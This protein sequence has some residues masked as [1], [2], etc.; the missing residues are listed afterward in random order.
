MKRYCSGM[1]VRLAFA[2]PLT[3]A[4][5]LVVDEVLAVGDAAFQKSAFETHAAL[6]SG[7]GTV[8][9]VSHNMGTVASLCKSALVLEDGR[10]IGRGEAREQV[11]LYMNALGE[12]IA[13]DVAARTDRGGNG[14]ARLTDIRLFDGHGKP[15]ESAMSG[16]PLTIRLGYRGRGPL[17][18]AEV[19]LRWPMSTD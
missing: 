9:F 6:G 13:V 1:Y 12:R 11:R 19:F 17:S 3:S 7:G 4:E 5:I 10:L 8:V 2:V 14:A 16:E 15:V 18:N